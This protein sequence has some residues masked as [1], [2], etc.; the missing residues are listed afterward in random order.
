MKSGKYIREQR[1]KLGMTQEDL[2]IKT[3]ISTRSIQR[4]ENG[5][6][7]PRSDSLQ[8]I[9]KAL[10]ISLEE[11]NE[12]ISDSGADQMWITAVHLSGLLFIVIPSILIWN[13]KKRSIPGIETHARDSI[14]FQL[15]L[16]LIIV[17][18]GILAILVITIPI[19]VITA[20]VGSF[21]IIINT[22]RVLLH[23][24]YHYPVAFHILKK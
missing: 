22:I 7:I 2:G 20:I 10:S 21:I 16:L 14:N 1:L 8:K 12:E 17:P 11:L 5:E 18:C 4:I 24:D 23:L 6:V 19:L 15:N 3:G 13:L 9:A